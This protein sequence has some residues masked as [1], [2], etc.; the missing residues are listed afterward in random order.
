MALKEIKTLADIED[1]ANAWK[2]STTGALLSQIQIGDTIYELKDLVARDS[3]EL[4]HD[5]VKALGEEDARLAG[6][7]GELQT[8]AQNLENNKA[9]K[10][11]VAKDIKDAVD[12]EAAIARA[13]E[14]ELDG[15][16]D[17]IELF[18]EG[19][20]EDGE[21]LQNALDTL[22]E[23]QDFI[24]VEGTTADAMIKDIA[25]NKKAIE[26]EAKA[27]ED[28]DK[29]F[30][31]R[32][33]D[34][35]A[36]LTG[37]EGSVGE[38]IEAAKDAAIEA[39]N[40]YTDGEIDKLGELAHADTAKGTVAG[41]TITGVKATGA[42]V[43]GV[44]LSDTANT[45]DITSTGKFTPAGN[46]SGTVTV[47][48]HDVP[49][50]VTNNDAQAVLATGTGVSNTTVTVTPSTAKVVDNITPGSLPTF[51]AGAF[52]AGDLETED[53]TIGAHN[54]LT[55]V[56]AGETL[57]FTSA[58]VNAISSKAVKNYVKP[59]KAADTFDAGSQCTFTTKDVVTGIDSANATVEYEKVTGVTYKKAE[60]NASG[61]CAG[62]TVAIDATFTGS[63]GAVSVGGQYTDTTYTAATTTGD[64]EL[65]VGPIAVEAKEVTVAATK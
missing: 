51:T 45:K 16:L 65:N 21:G 53:V 22:K 42:A 52:D 61:T 40:Q 11:Q 10:T 46:V 27:R 57:S 23:I 17:K 1:I 9:D 44:T 20:A 58:M 60:E 26:D 38:Q 55:A 30:D 37:G 12:A 47:L 64:I 48:P 59:S 4:L 41:Q 31:E 35:E 28:A 43:N 33:D 32:L 8:A 62:S 19:A 50:T 18:F 49:V 2:N 34:V 5:L 63:E 6:L 7:V 14:G 29:A 24:N 56:V 54:E 25:D 3:I 15:R 39:A 36:L 13:A